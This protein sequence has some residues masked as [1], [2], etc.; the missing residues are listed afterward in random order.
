MYVYVYKTIYINTLASDNYLQ[1]AD[2]L[3]GRRTVTKNV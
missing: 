2:F 3:E 1:A